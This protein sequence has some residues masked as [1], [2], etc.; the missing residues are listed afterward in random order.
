[1]A[2]DCHSS[3]LPCGSLQKTLAGSVT[4]HLILELSSIMIGIK[5]THFKNR[6][7]MREKILRSST[8]SYFYKY[9]HKYLLLLAV[10]AC[11]VVFLRLTSWIFKIDDSP[12]LSQASYQF[13]SQIFFSRLAIFSCPTT[14][15]P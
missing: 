8:L 12:G 4:L 7:H 2:L 1:M 13:T 14:L 9:F 10:S 3:L 6:L 15:S 5:S 11:L